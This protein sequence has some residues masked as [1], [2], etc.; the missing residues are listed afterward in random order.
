MARTK[1]DLAFNISP[2]RKYIMPRPRVN[3]LIARASE[4]K[5]V[6]MIAGAGYGKTAAVQ[7]YINGQKG[8]IVRWLQLTESDN[9]ASHYWENYTHSTSHDNPKLAKEL[10][11]LGFPET[12]TRFK[13]FADIL[14]RGERNSDKTILVLDDF[15]LINSKKALTFAERCAQL[16]APNAC[17][18]II[19]RAEPEINTVNILSKGKLAVITQDDLRFTKEEIQDFFKWR[20]FTCTS[21]MAERFAESTKGWPLAINLLSHIMSNSLGNADMALRLTEQ[22]IHKLFESEAWTVFPEDIKKTLVKLSLVPQSPHSQLQEIFEKETTEQT[23]QLA[24][25]ISYDSF[26]DNYTL[27]PLYLSFLREKQ[28]ILSKEEKQSTYEEAAT[29]CFENGFYTIAVKYYAAAHNFERILEVLRTYQENWAK[30]TC[31]FFLDII[32]NI[33]PDTGDNV[34]ENPE[35]TRLKAL[36]KPFLLIGI[37]EFEHAEKV[38]EKLVQEWEQTDSPHRE[39]VLIN[40]YT[41]LAQISKYTC[42][43]T[44]EFKTAQHLKKVAELSAAGITAETSGIFSLAG[45][46]SFACLVGENATLEVIDKFVESTKELVAT[47]KTITPK[48]LYGYDDWAQCEI[49]YFKNDLDE[50]IISAQ[51]GIIKARENSHSGVAMLLRQFMQRIAIHRGDYPLAKE[52]LI[53]MYESIGKIGKYRGQLLYD[54]ITASFY[55]HIGVPEMVAP[56][57]FSEPDIGESSDF[58]IPTREL[59][60]RV[61]YYLECNKYSQSLAVLNNSYPRPPYE[62]FLFS[63][64]IFSL[65]FAVAQMKTGDAQ[66]AVKSLER[67]YKLSHDGLFE[68]PFIEMGKHI[69]P[70]I[71]AVSE[72]STCIPTKWLGA[73]ERKATIFAKNVAVI[74]NTFKRE[75]K[76]QKKISLSG[77]EREVL[78]D[79]CK[80]L[81]RD[82][83]AQYRFLSINTVK[84][85][86]QSLY[87]KLDASNNLDAVR[88]AF[89]LNL[90]G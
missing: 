30:D 45:I 35:L 15:H 71:T 33:E 57:I 17:V 43:S 75:H 31:K 39:E 63:E 54:I 34:R 62:R 66:S 59:I 77:R 52:F 88:I 86:L 26:S 1:K 24:S 36:T 58:R 78:S 25:F 32:E 22:N 84:K 13:Q 81:T 10:K 44:H 19:S 42:V 64:L 49:A 85:V 11:E 82:E 65:F 51:R 72:Q 41:A 69:T 87:I 53:Q 6:Y 7:N 38:T 14:K 5:L 9:V 28:E 80:G 61:R 47:I 37:G 89:E 50:A 40:A 18:I 83:I 48:K 74:E 20:K 76:I 2:L 55:S 67:A 73:T 4:C 8:A 70:V 21:E 16:R 29:W 23:A 12:A 46:R 90:V 60:V 79:M 27:H 68:M 56:W 3:D